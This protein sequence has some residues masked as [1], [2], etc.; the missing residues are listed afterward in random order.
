[1]GHIQCVD[2]RKGNIVAQHYTIHCTNKILPHTFLNLN[3]YKVKATKKY[4]TRLSTWPNSVFNLLASVLMILSSSYRYTC[5]LMAWIT[6]ITYFFR[7]GFSYVPN[8]LKEIFAE[9]SQLNS[10]HPRWKLQL[11]LIREIACGGHCRGGEGEVIT[12]W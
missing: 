10:V 7:L 6:L 2:V 8:Q 5:Y 1:M 3:N 9:P 4:L 11:Y 12:I